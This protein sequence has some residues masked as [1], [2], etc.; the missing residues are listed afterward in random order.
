MRK[1]ESIKELT[2]ALAKAQ[3]S[4]CPA[5]KESENPFFKSKYAD[6]A[7]VWEA[8]RKSLSDNGLAIIQTTDM[9]ENNLVVITTLTHSS[10]EWVEGVLPINPVKLDPQGIGSAITYAR[11]YSLSAIVGISVDDDDG[12]SAM[13]RDKGNQIPEPQK[14]Q[15]KTPNDKTGKHVVTVAEV[16][17]MLLELS[18]EDKNK[19]GML[20]ETFTSFTGK[21]GKIVLGRKTLAGISDAQLNI[22]YGRAKDL[23]AERERQ[24]DEIES[25]PIPQKWQDAPANLIKDARENLGWMDKK[26]MQIASIEMDELKLMAEV[27][28]LFELSA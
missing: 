23:L 17:R 10:G 1:S 6:L 9:V 8:C 5:K 21:D 22:V 27:H 11:R 19:A 20:L 13:G 24:A 16:G 28:R 3:G 2:I 15:P 26:Y 18:N 7:A 4:M 12:E 14:R 25:D